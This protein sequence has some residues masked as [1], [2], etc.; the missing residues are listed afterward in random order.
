MVGPSPYFEGGFWS[1]KPTQMSL[2]RGLSNKNRFKRKY[3]EGNAHNQKETHKRHSRRSR[4][5][6]LLP[7]IFFSEQNE[8]ETWRN[9]KNITEVKG[10]PGKGVEVRN[11]WALRNGFKSNG[12]WLNIYWLKGH[13]KI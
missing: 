12:T 9:Q 10:H 8:L 4:H 6:L 2:F 11:F 3:K 1:E 5:L 7:T 13:S